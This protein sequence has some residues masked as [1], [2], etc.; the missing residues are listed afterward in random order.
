[1]QQYPENRG[2]NNIVA[3]PQQKRGQKK[4][5]RRSRTAFGGDLI[6]ERNKPNQLK[7]FYN[8]VF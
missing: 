5:K 6:T 4:E 1:M 2:K 7:P 8:Q 3:K